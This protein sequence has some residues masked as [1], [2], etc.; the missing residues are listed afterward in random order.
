M[1]K[2]SLISFDEALLEV[3]EIKHTLILNQIEN[4]CVKQGL[5]SQLD[6]FTKSEQHKWLVDV[7]ENHII[8]AGLLQ[9]AMIEHESSDSHEELYRS[10]V[11]DI[12][13][14]LLSHQKPFPRQ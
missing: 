6:I 12:A 10:I 3:K 11:C 8:S 1:E 5:I 14:R 7:I 13:E 9:E 4:L 2:N